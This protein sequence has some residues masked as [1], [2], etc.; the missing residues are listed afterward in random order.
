VLSARTL[1]EIRAARAALAAW[2]ARHPE[3][4]GSEA[5]FEQLNLMER[6]WGEEPPGRIITSNAPGFNRPG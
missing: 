2:L 1:P 6:S 3:D 4:G 5:G